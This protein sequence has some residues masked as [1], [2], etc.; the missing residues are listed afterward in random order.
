MLPVIYQFNFDTL[1]SQLLL[2]LFALGLVAYAAWAGWRGAAGPR[3]PKTGE[4]K[5]PSRNDQLQRA[6]IFG[7]I[8]AGIAGVG[9]HFALPKSALLG[10]KGEGIPIHTYGV[11]IATGF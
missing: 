1:P 9:L 2:Y 4:L 10:G 3:D 6:V 5:E 7:V 11:M 8:G